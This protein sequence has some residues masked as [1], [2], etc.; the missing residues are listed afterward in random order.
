[1]TIS[2]RWSWKIN[3]ITEVKHHQHIR[4]QHRRQQLIVQLQLPRSSSTHKQLMDH[5]DVVARLDKK[6]LY[7]SSHC[8]TDAWH[9][10]LD[11]TWQMLE[12]CWLDKTWQMVEMCQLTICLSN[13]HQCMTVICHFKQFVSCQTQAAMC[14]S[15]SDLETKYD[16]L[17]W[18]E[19]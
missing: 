13:D 14:S 5:L 10:W 17:R 12:M 3:I 15:L 2:T 7:I 9:S 19:I 18:K 4:P 1:M 11:K 16:C 6:K 8:L